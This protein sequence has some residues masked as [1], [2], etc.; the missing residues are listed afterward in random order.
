MARHLLPATRRG[1]RHARRPLTAVLTAA[2]LT[3]AAATAADAA[4]RSGLA[5]NDIPTT[6]DNLR[7]WIIGIL[8][9]VATLLLTVGGTRYLMAGGDPG[10]IEKAKTAL[11]ASAIGYVLAL[12]APPIVA[13]LKNVVGA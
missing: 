6:I 1:L 4:V 11:K 3:L 7:N 12:L 13:V 8:A 5:V 10:E 9:T 2:L